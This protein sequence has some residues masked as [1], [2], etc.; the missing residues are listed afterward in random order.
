MSNSNKDNKSKSV[1]TY[2]IFKEEV[3]TKEKKR[4][5]KK[6]HRLISFILIDISSVVV[7]KMGERFKLQLLNDVKESI[8]KALQQKISQRAH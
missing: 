3:F 5:E 2:Q 4:F 7:L 1:K 6:F 8:F